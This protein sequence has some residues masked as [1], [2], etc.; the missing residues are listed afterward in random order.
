MRRGDACFAAPFRLHFVA[1]SRHGSLPQVAG[2]LRFLSERFSAETILLSTFPAVFSQ[3]KGTP[4]YIMLSRRWHG[5]RYISAHTGDIV[6]ASPLSIHL[7]KHVLIIKVA[8]SSE[9]LL[10]W[11][12]LLTTAHAEAS[13]DTQARNMV[14]FVTADSCESVLAPHRG[15]RPGS[16]RVAAMREA[17]HEHSVTL[18]DE[19]AR[20]APAPLPVPIDTAGTASNTVRYSPQVRDWSMPHS[21]SLTRP[22]EDSGATKVETHSSTRAALCRSIRRPAPVTARQTGLCSVPRRALFLN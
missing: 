5:F 13:A 22:N 12:S 18:W 3:C 6:M 14:P 8:G 10:A 9:T 1:L 2:R 7:L 16:I 17:S 15:C 19:L 4:I 11:F 21:A 20:P